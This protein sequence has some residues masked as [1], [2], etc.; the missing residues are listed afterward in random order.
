MNEM[1][2]VKFNTVC[3]SIGLDTWGSGNEI[4]TVYSVCIIY[5]IDKKLFYKDFN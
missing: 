1:I 3:K 5:C 2:S 4:S